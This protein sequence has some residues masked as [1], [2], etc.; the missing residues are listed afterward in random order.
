MNQALDANNSMISDSAQCELPLAGRGFSGRARQDVE[1]GAY[2]DVLT[3]SA[4]PSASQRR[5]IEA[6]SAG[7][8]PTKTTAR[9]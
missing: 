5:R 1:P 7:F 2:M 3:A 9:F 8:A 4:E 6:K